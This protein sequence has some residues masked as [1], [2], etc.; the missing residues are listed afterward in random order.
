[1]F[2]V[3]FF[4]RKIIIHVLSDSGEAFP[5]NRKEKLWGRFKMLCDVSL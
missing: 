4:L 3:H 5:P 1:M 2:S